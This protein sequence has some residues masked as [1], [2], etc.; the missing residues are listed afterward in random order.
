MPERN[1]W[2][3]KIID[4][5]RANQGRVG[6]FFQ[7]APITLIHHRGRKSGRAYVTPVMY[8]S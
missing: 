2:N 6:G 7:D 8:L 3:A 5:F 4:E 1:D